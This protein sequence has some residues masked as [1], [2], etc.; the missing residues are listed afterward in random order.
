MRNKSGGRTIC[1]YRFMYCGS[2]TFVFHG[3]YVLSVSVETATLIPVFSYI[4]RIG[5]S[6]V[7]FWMDTLVSLLDERPDAR[8]T[9]TGI[10]FD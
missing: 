4:F 1:E 9:N 5:R 7:Y 8:S 2:T 6:F 3:I 10:L